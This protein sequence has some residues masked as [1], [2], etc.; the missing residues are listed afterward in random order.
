MH[1]GGRA[2]PF[3]YYILVLLLCLL[4]FA[5]LAAAG[6]T[7]DSTQITRCGDAYTARID[8]GTV[9]CGTKKC[10]WTSSDTNVITISGGNKGQTVSYQGAG[11][12]T[13]KLKLSADGTN[14]DSAD[15]KV[16]FGPLTS[17]T[18][19]WGS[20]GDSNKNPAAG[21]LY[22][23][24]I[25]AKDCKGEYK[26]DNNA[27][28]KSDPMYFWYG[29]SKNPGIMYVNQTI[30][31]ENESDTSITGTVNLDWQSCA[32]LSTGGTDC[33]E[34]DKGK[35]KYTDWRCLCFYRFNQSDNGK[36]EFILHAYGHIP[37]IVDS[38]G[39]SV[40]CKRCRVT[41]IDNYFTNGSSSPVVTVTVY[42]SPVPA[43]LD[44]FIVDAPAQEAADTNFDMAVDAADSEGYNVYDYGKSK[45]TYDGDTV[46][47]EASAVTGGSGAKMTLDK[48]TNKGDLKYECQ[49]NLFS[50]G[51]LALKMKISA[52][53]R[54]KITATS[55]NNG[56][57]GTDAVTIQAVPTKLRVDVPAK[58]YEDIP[59]TAT[60]YV[61]DDQGHPVPGSEKIP[62]TLTL[63]SPDGATGTI[64]CGSGP[65]QSCTCKPDPLGG[66]CSATVIPTLHGTLNVTATATK[67]GGGDLTKGEG[68]TKVIESWCIEYDVK[69]PAPGT[70]GDVMQQIPYPSTG[71]EMT[72]I[73]SKGLLN[74]INATNMGIG[75][76][77]I[78]LDAAGT[79][80]DTPESK[81]CAFNTAKTHVKFCVGDDGGGM[82]AAE[83]GIFCIHEHV[84]TPTVDSEIS[85]H[86]NFQSNDLSHE[87]LV[88][89]FYYPHL[90]WSWGFS[91]V[92]LGTLFPATCGAGDRYQVN[93]TK[94]TAA[95]NYFKLNV[96][97][98][99]SATLPPYDILTAPT[100]NPH[101][102]KGVAGI[103]TLQKIPASDNSQLSLFNLSGGTRLEHYPNSI[104]P[105]TTFN[106]ANAMAVDRKGDLYVAD[107]L[108]MRILLFKAGQTNPRTVSAGII[109]SS[110][111][112][113]Y[114]DKTNGQ[115][116]YYPLGIAFDSWNKMYIVGYTTVP[117]TDTD[118]LVIQVLNADS[119]HTELASWQETPTADFDHSTASIAVDQRG[120]NIYVGTADESVH[121]YTLDGSTIS[122]A[123]PATYAVWI[124]CRHLGGGCWSHSCRGMGT[125]W[126]GTNYANDKCLN[127]TQGHFELDG[128]SNDDPDA[129]TTQLDTNVHGVRGQY[130]ATAGTWAYSAVF[131]QI[132]TVTQ[133]EHDGPKSVTGVTHQVEGMFYKKGYLYFIDKMSYSRNEGRG[134][135]NDCAWWACDS[136][137]CWDCWSWVWALPPYQSWHSYAD[138]LG[139]YS[140]NCNYCGGGTSYDR[141][142]FWLRVYYSDDAG[143]LVPIFHGALSNTQYGSYQNNEYLYSHEGAGL[144]SGRTSWGVGD[145]TNPAEYD[146]DYFGWQW[147][148][149]AGFGGGGGTAKMLNIPGDEGIADVTGL[150]VDDDS[151]V[152]MAIAGDGSSKGNDV[153]G[154]WKV[155]IKFSGKTFI[156]ISSAAARISGTESL[157]N[158]SAVVVYP[159]LVETMASL[160]VYCEGC[161]DRAGMEMD[162]CK[163]E[164][165]RTA[166]GGSGGGATSKFSEVQP[167]YTGIWLDTVINGS[168]AIT[169]TADLIPCPGKGGTRYN[170]AT[171]TGT[172]LNISNHL[173]STVEG[174][175]FTLVFTRPYRSIKSPPPQGLPTLTYE[176]Y[177]SRYLFKHFV[178]F[179][180][181]T[182]Q[183]PAESIHIVNS[184][185]RFNFT[186]WSNSFYGYEYATT[187]INMFENISTTD[188]DLNP[189]GGQTLLPN[190]GYDNVSLKWGIPSN[191][192]FKPVKIVPNPIP[193]YGTGGGDNLHI[194]S[195][196]GRS[197][198]CHGNAQPKL[199][200][201][202]VGRDTSGATV[203]YTNETTA[204]CGDGGD[205]IERPNGVGV[206]QPV[207]VKD[208]YSITVKNEGTDDAMG[209][210][211]LG[212][213]YCSGTDHLCAVFN[214]DSGIAA[215]PG[216]EEVHFPYV[217]A[218]GVSQSTTD[219]V[220]EAAPD[221]DAPWATG[222]ALTA[223][224]IR[225][226]VKPI[227]I[228]GQ[229]GLT[230][231]GVNTTG[232][233]IIGG[234]QIMGEN[235]PNYIGG[236][237]GTVTI[238]AAAAAHVELTF[239]GYSA[240]NTFQ[241]V[242][243]T[244]DLAAGGNKA[245]DGAY[246]AGKSIQNLSMVFV[247][248]DAQI[249]A[250]VIPDTAVGGRLCVPTSPYADTYSGGCA[251][252]IDPPNGYIAND[253]P[254]HFVPSQ[255]F[256]PVTPVKPENYL[257]L[258]ITRISGNGA[259]FGDRFEVY[260]DARAITPVWETDI[261]EGSDGTAL[262]AASSLF[263]GS[264]VDVNVSARTNVCCNHT[265]RVIVST[266][267]ED[268]CTEKAQDAID[269][270][271]DKPDSMFKQKIADVCGSSE[272]NANKTCS[273]KRAGAV[274]KKGAAKDSAK[275][276]DSN[277]P[278]Y[279]DCELGG[280]CTSTVD[281]D[282]EVC[283][284][285]KKPYYC[286][287]SY[288]R[289]D[290]EEPIWR[291]PFDDTAACGFCNSSSTYT[292][293]GKDITQDCNETGGRRADGIDAACDSAGYFYTMG[294]ATQIDVNVVGLNAAG[295]LTTASTAL[296]DN[297]EKVFDKNHSLTYDKGGPFA[298]VY[299]VTVSG[300]QNQSIHF[301]DPKGTL[302]RADLANVTDYSNESAIMRFDPPGARQLEAISNRSDTKATVR[303]AG[304]DSSGKAIDETLDL[305]TGGTA[306]AKTINDFAALYFINVTEKVGADGKYA[307]VGG[308]HITVRT[309]P[310]PTTKPPQLVGTITVGPAK[311]VPAAYQNATGM[312]LF[313]NKDDVSFKIIDN[314][315]LGFHNVNWTFYDRFANAFIWDQPFNFTLPTQ[316]VVT[317]IAER[318]NTDPNLTHVTVRAQLFFS[319]IDEPDKPPSNP[320]GNYD[321][322]FWEWNV[323]RSS[324][325]PNYVMEK[326]NGQV[327]ASSTYV[328]SC[329]TVQITSGSS[330]Y[331][332]FKCYDQASGGI[333]QNTCSSDTDCSPPDSTCRHMVFC[334]LPGSDSFECGG[335]GHTCTS[336][337]T[338]ERSGR[339]MHNYGFVGQNRTCNVTEIA[340]NDRGCGSFAEGETA[341][342]FDV[343]GWGR[344]RL[345][346]LFDPPAGSV[347]SRTMTV[348]PYYSGGFPLDIGTL[349]VWV[350]FAL[351]L[352]LVAAKLFW[353]RKSAAAPNARA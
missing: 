67:P 119:G 42:P 189:P 296:N 295:D 72:T 229:T 184:T 56:A 211:G 34:D 230:I 53:G 6:I 44:H 279:C 14:Y 16:T 167:Q 193:Y 101:E 338:C 300:G 349:S 200:F 348:S 237:S 260:D 143:N 43:T 50:G 191:Y 61:L 94:I 172:A 210:V 346:A 220:I 121:H 65:V 294:S 139:G 228:S 132:D 120:I 347:F 304:V 175:M 82:F 73:D 140:G 133:P 31:W 11:T 352:L 130:S 298:E 306:S 126:D 160:G 207:Q 277:N 75:N 114:T 177:S 215:G 135:N 204:S 23:I 62:I 188:K 240:G 310:L 308:E 213:M 353:D 9:D 98:T 281:K 257:F 136:A 217:P 331:Q 84:Y 161:D 270:C 153:K 290:K 245:F 249:Y 203:T 88:N 156:D 259:Q 21:S 254:T 263:S 26:D 86:F 286:A 345:V 194:C 227:G 85:D 32:T 209:M 266:P 334:T 8:T 115:K 30:H 28:Y 166:A 201:T 158:L 238:Y 35:N 235:L 317:P 57:S 299:R 55:A 116:P 87:N 122:L 180:N 90:L 144:W 77:L 124:P 63:G 322:T 69:P 223:T 350:P 79:L 17:I 19:E 2:S 141:H 96:T 268:V 280:M 29:S 152:Y 179:D 12:G 150:F 314:A 195:C 183:P 326:N 332:G 218:K 93:F 351:I 234:A 272:E 318:D 283:R 162:V 80:K 27:N 106:N 262:K 83:P 5:Q 89:T 212:N 343:C 214:L 105:D 108:N 329:D 92:P 305:S 13:A 275:C 54:Y 344:H 164:Q 307:G 269:T 181:V 123:D 97:M 58:I 70:G 246:F 154:L 33:Y 174:G 224:G 241:N 236:S 47:I 186:R 102:I 303:L 46:T 233:S 117:A 309:A 258:N 323:T 111:T 239:Q 125:Y 253:P 225:L 134:K 205:M 273:D 165:S 170:G 219:A 226:M 147:T 182:T 171:I 321:L 289:I 104:P 107:T 264:L 190:A 74:A 333:T 325:A 206:N 99:G 185:Y 20:G 109:P 59:Y 341:V 138:V 284:E 271:L 297:N 137:D 48:C 221:E 255:E 66:G 110:G 342:S 250:V 37:F 100:K 128:S 68:T 91:G 103:Y 187:N 278:Y 248:T 316:I 261:E 282:T 51:A 10:E 285:D 168:A 335:T 155:Q 202:I 311:F 4:S 112:L 64:D 146:Y 265:L 319:R 142:E 149:V 39:H 324:T 287:C 60:A 315:S 231:T 52:S 49:A 251:F 312:Y 276:S 78:N 38:A 148:A 81:W 336:S 247:G 157:D 242:D 36:K 252:K 129:S 196:A 151:N 320:L 76:S 243:E 232:D 173:N 45:T 25:T 95:P 256:Y 340:N 131:H 267:L 327:D 40:T 208:L 15:I 22:N 178:V 330:S 3:P 18:S 293:Y 328:C 222:V 339:C 274:C 7:V 192:A 159:D 302:I 118:I 197:S 288:Q 337:Y 1:R 244:F 292:G 198:V 176:P 41:Q 216:S 113:T 71:T 313:A 24:S 127:D 169:Y 301:T 163:Q 145:G 199:E 291:L